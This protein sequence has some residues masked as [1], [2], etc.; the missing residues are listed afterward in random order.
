VG[1]YSPAHWS[2]LSFEEHNQI[3]KDCNKQG[4][5]GETKHN[6]AQVLFATDDTS[7]LTPNTTTQAGN[8]F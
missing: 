6:V 3:H 2:K 5:Q 7:K 1:Y 4:K 8:A